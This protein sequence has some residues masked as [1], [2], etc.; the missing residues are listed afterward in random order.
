M[1]STINSYSYYFAVPPK[2]SRTDVILSPL[3][4]DSVNLSWKPA[5][6]P[7]YQ[8]LRSPITYSIF[9]QEYPSME[10][11]PV[12]N[13]ITQLNYRVIGLKPDRDYRFRLQAQ[14]DSGISEPTFPVLL[15]RKPGMK[16]LNLIS[17]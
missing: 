16:I 6:V 13:R 15:Q 4:N 2:L 14:T 17:S 3:G 1:S 12:A 11:M 10:W 7:A 9:M 8:Q 5:E